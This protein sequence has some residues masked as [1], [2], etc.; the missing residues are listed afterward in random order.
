[1]TSAVLG[2]FREDRRTRGEFM[3]LLKGNGD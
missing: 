1:V 3:D 2:A